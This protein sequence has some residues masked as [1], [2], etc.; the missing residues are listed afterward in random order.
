MAN[1]LTLGAIN[2]AHMSEDI[3]NLTLQRFAVQRR[4]VR[5]YE[6][7]WTSREVGRLELEQA[8]KALLLTLEAGVELGLITPS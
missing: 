5:E 3:A 7:S 2:R 1:T 8:N 6:T 4:W